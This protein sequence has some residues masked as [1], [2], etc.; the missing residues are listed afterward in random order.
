MG[1]VLAARAGYDPYGLPR[2]LM[3]FAQNDGQ[4]GF[5]LFFSTHPA[6]DARLAALADYLNEARFAEL[7][8]TGV[9]NT[10]DFKRVRRSLR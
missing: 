2:A 4:S 3:M 5:D 8:K 10:A 1:V 9:Q 6:P 7:E